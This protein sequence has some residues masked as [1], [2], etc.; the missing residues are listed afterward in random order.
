[1]RKFTDVYTAASCL[2]GI[3]V[4]ALKLA[5]YAAD[6]KCGGFRWEIYEGENEQISNSEKD[7]VPLKV[8]IAMRQAA[9]YCW[10]AEG[11]DPKYFHE[12]MK[13]S[14]SGKSKNTFYHCRIECHSKTG[15]LLHQFESSEH[16]AKK[17]GLEAECIN[18]ALWNP[19]FPENLY[20]KWK[21]SY[22]D[23]VTSSFSEKSNEHNCINLDCGSCGKSFDSGQGLSNHKRRNCDST[24]KTSKTKSI[25]KSSVNVQQNTDRK[26]PSSSKVKSNHSQAR[27]HRIPNHDPRKRDVANEDEDKSE[28][29]SRD[30]TVME[31]DGWLLNSNV[32]MDHPY[33]SQ[34]ELIGQPTIRNFPNHA[35]VSGAVEAYYPDQDVWRNIHDDGDAEDLEEG[36]IREAIRK[37][38]K[39]GNKNKNNDIS[40]GENISKINHQLIPPSNASLMMEGNT[41]TRDDG[42]DECYSIDES[43]GGGVDTLIPGIDSNQGVPLDRNVVESGSDSL[44][45]KREDE[46][47]DTSTNHTNKRIAIKSKS[48]KDKEFPILPPISTLSAIHPPTLHCSIPANSYR[49]ED[50]SPDSF[51]TFESIEA[52]SE[53][54]DQ[55]TLID[56]NSTVIDGNST[57]I[58]GNGTLIDGNSSLS[59]SINDIITPSSSNGIIT[60]APNV[61]TSVGTV[62]VPTRGGNEITTDDLPSTG[63]EITIDDPPST[64]NEITTDD[65]PSTGTELTTDDLPSTEKDSYI[66]QVTGLPFSILI[67]MAIASLGMNSEGYDSSQIANQ[68]VHFIKGAFIVLSPERRAEKRAIV[69]AEYC[70]IVTRILNKIAKSPEEVEEEEYVREGQSDFIYVSRDPLNNNG[71]D[72]RYLLS[73]S[74]LEKV[75]YLTRISATI[76]I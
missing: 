6:N 39:V 4:A 8:L 52:F 56:G 49:Q 43:M 16:A 18:D 40:H 64:G 38:L 67:S 21:W 48:I 60:D 46:E 37:A 31:A 42:D 20:N 28:E 41:N 30:H 66:V 29:S 44:K 59:Q 47:E 34:C 57:L 23:R 7:D 73:T 2:E 27:S 1:M 50:F 71:G 76:N 62:A 5:L 33:K 24:M 10:L 51:E 35:V 25:K 9:N 55:C 63:N 22:S 13:D 68:M 11:A 75:A 53:G 19:Q 12:E 65:P 14:Q 72:K 17:L 36:A 74:G 70:K 32:P 26:L 69:T 45:R 3:A 61:D 54:D 58:D 15:D